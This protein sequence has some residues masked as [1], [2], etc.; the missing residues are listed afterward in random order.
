MNKQNENNKIISSI[1][2]SVM[3]IGEY[4]M[5]VGT[6][7]A[8]VIGSIFAADKI[9]GS[10]FNIMQWLIITVYVLYSIA[11]G[12]RLFQSIAIR[13]TKNDSMEAGWLAYISSIIP[14]IIFSVWIAFVSGV[15]MDQNTKEKQSIS[16]V[17]VESAI[18]PE[19]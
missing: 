14:C 4:I 12:A 18:V 15:L 8:L 6:F 2:N 10:I 17:K 11:A 3:E 1:T 13:Y 16:E 7:S 9:E 5:K 19:K